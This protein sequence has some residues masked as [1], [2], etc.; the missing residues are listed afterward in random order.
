MDE[1]SLRRLTQFL[2]TYKTNHGRDANEAELMAAGFDAAL[3]GAAVRKGLVDKYQ[4]TN[5]KGNLENRFKLHK[6]WRTL[7]L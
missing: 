3:I 5:P 7:K 4:V 2:S 1:L 6:D